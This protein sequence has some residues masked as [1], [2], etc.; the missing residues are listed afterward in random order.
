M[1]TAPKQ[2]CLNSEI[3]PIT[4]VLVKSCSPVP[5]TSFPSPPHTRGISRDTITIMFGPHNNS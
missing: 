4:P 2:L 5:V 3:F 1:Q